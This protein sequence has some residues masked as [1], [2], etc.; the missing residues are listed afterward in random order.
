MWAF[1]MQD[2]GAAHESRTHFPTAADLRVSARL[3]GEASRFVGAIEAVATGPGPKQAVLKLMPSH[4]WE[5]S[6][7]LRAC[8]PL[9]CY[10]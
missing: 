8:F 9:L 5:S 6:F 4:C 3:A 7:S 10:G 2:S 1:N